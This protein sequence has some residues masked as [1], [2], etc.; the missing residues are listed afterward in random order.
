MHYIHFRFHAMI[1]SIVLVCTTLLSATTT[2]SAAEAIQDRNI[3]SPASKIDKPVILSLQIEP[4]TLNANAMNSLKIKLKFSDKGQNL[5]DGVL[6][7]ELKESNDYSHTISFDLKSNK[8]KRTK[9]K[10]NFTKDLL[11]GNCKSVEVVAYLKD[12]TQ[13]KSKKRVLS[14]NAIGY[15]D[16][17]DDDNPEWGTKIGQRAENFTLLDQ[18]GNQVSLHDYIGKVILLDLST[19]WCS[20]CQAEAA[21][22]EELY[23]AYKLR[24]FI[25]LSVLCQD[26][27]GGPPATSDCKA[28]ANLYGL[29]FPV[30]ADN[31]VNVWNLY[32]DEGY[33]PLNLIIDKKM[34]IQYKDAGYE[35]AIKESFIQI[36]EE[37]L[38]K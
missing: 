11:I 28:W 38:E 1:A 14:V 9:G 6:E 24:G 16:S 2:I 22:A 10:F 3:V 37:L 5:K 26:Y 35:P 33:I 7:L 34:V 25:I 29:T 19:M 20:P 23:Q 8:F 15:M 18:N 4:K 12:A 30:L 21:E 13:L 31:N 36:I 17:G 27:I 32:D